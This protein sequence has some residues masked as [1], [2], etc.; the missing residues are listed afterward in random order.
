MSSII[1]KSKSGS[2]NPKK[3]KIKTVTGDHL[4]EQTSDLETIPLNISQL[5]KRRDYIHI[6]ISMENILYRE[7]PT[8]TASDEVAPH[9]K[10]KPFVM[11]LKNR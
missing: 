5:V 7:L 3:I 2:Y 10:R 11:E 8:F 9:I 6:F 1:T 4:G